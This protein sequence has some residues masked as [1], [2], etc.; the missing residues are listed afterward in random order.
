MWSPH[1]LSVSSS[2]C[3]PQTFFSS[4]AAPTRLRFPPSNS[5][6]GETQWHLY[7]TK[8]D[9][10][11]ACCERAVPVIDPLPGPWGEALGLRRHSS[12]YSTAQD[13]MSGILR[14]TRR[15]VF[16]PYCLCPYPAA[17]S[18]YVRI[19]ALPRLLGFIS[20]L[21]RIPIDSP[22]TFLQIYLPP[23]C[24][25]TPWSLVEYCQTLWLLPGLDPGWAWLCCS[26]HNYNFF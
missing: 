10:W 26:S 3:L 24:P 22:P 7:V 11:N 25:W 6:V 2:S 17:T 20:S 13:P 21:G 14:R 15:L 5:K 4:L 12:R 19:S 1:N 18:K 9:P 23:S 8:S 16:S